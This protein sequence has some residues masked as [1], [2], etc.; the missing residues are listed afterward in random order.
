VEAAAAAAAAGG[1]GDEKKE[2]AP[3]KSKS[4]NVALVGKM[5]GERWK[6]LTDE[7]KEVYHARSKELKEAYEA[8]I[9]ADPSLAPVRAK[10]VVASGG[11]NEGANSHEAL[12][13]L[14]RIKK[15]MELDEN[16]GRMT[17]EALLV[18]EKAAVSDQGTQSM[19]LPRCSSCALSCFSLSFSRCRR[20][21]L[22]CRRS[23]SSPGFPLAPT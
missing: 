7:E 22:L 6:L 1:E 23:I 20:S 15:V 5:L 9:L 21:M 14:A 12:L 17:K 4:R 19:S 16:R 11:A 18:T 8:A 10:R 2:A 13:P 3:V